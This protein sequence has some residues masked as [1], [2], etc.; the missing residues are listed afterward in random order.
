MEDSINNNNYFF[1]SEDVN[2]EEHV[3]HLISDNKNHD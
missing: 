1:S 3:L 2:D